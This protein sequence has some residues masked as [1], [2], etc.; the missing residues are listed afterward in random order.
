[1]TSLPCRPGSAY[2]HVTQG[3]TAE[4]SRISASPE[5][6][7]LRPSWR[8]PLFKRP[9]PGPGICI[10]IL[11]SLLVADHAAS[12]CPMMCV[13]GHKVGLLSL[14]WFNFGVIF[15]TRL[16]RT[17]GTRRR[18]SGWFRKMDL[19]LVIRGVNA[20]GG[21]ANLLFLSPLLLLVVIVGSLITL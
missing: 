5:M 11:I 17:D 10:L 20:T 14:G 7:V 1:M 4:V 9:R 21:G 8:C 19:L 18:K 16:L 15:A 6:Q 2:P 3:L 13:P 12:H